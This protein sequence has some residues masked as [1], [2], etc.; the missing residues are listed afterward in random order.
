MGTIILTD[1]S[2]NVVAHKADK[3][4]RGMKPGRDHSKTELRNSFKGRTSTGMEERKPAKP[5]RKSR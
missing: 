4:G 3:G 1:K 2:K 5:A